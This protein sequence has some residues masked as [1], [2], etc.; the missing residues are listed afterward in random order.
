MPA[1]SV[2]RGSPTMHSRSAVG[3]IHYFTKETA[4]V[5]LKDTGYEIMDYVH[6]SGL[7]ELPNRSWKAKILKFHR[8]LCFSLEQDWAAKIFGGFSLLVLAR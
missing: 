3:H 4:L 8:R 1:Q 5:K 6:T 2:L 7:L